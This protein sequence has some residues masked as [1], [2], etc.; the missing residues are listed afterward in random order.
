MK[1][2]SIFYLIILILPHM[3]GKKKSRSIYILETKQDVNEK[4]VKRL[5]INISESRNSAN[6]L[7]ELNEDINEIW[8]SLGISTWI[9][10][11]N[12]F[13]SMIAYDIELCDTL[14]RIKSSNIQMLSTWLT[15]F[16]KYGNLSNTC[17]FE[18]NLYYF[19]NLKVEKESIPAF[20]PLGKFRSHVNFY[21]KKSDDS[22]EI[23]G[24]TEMTFELK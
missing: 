23:M 5:E 11:L 9:K 6:I 2:I 1:L 16:L 15:N 10:Q 21:K 3:E 8:A 12:S 18:K 14:A 24:N 19:E 7:F 17:P 4:Y 13:R 20:A 22:K